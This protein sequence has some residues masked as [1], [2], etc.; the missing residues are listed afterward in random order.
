MW[1]LCFRGRCV[2]LTWPRRYLRAEQQQ[3]VLALSYQPPCPLSPHPTLPPPPAS[4][5]VQLTTNEL[6]AGILLQMTHDVASDDRC[7]VT[8][9]VHS[10]QLV[11]SRGLGHTSA[12]CVCVC[13]CTSVCVCARLCVCVCARVCVCVCACMHVCERVCGSGSGCGVCFFI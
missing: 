6:R 7:L 2:Q 12:S 11:L 3:T 5:D 13:V 4:P 10:Q 8:S 1:F 9:T